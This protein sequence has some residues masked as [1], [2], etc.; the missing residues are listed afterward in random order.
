MRSDAFLLWAET[1]GHLLVTSCGCSLRTK[2]AVRNP[3]YKADYRQEFI[4]YPDLLARKIPILLD[5]ELFVRILVR[6]TS[7]LYNTNTHYAKH[8]LP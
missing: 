1:I 5:H 2:K 7:S 3:L 4:A 6:D 8:I